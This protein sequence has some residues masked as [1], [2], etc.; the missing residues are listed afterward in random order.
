[1]V[2]YQTEVVAVTETDNNPS[3]HMGIMGVAVSQ[4]NY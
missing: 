4:L 3:M 1:M 2:T